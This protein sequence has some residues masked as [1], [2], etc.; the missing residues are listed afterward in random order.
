MGMSP[1]I[2]LSLPA[3]GPVPELAAAAAN[4]GSGVGDVAGLSV[5][6]GDTQSFELDVALGEF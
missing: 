4:N 3:I 2:T 5:G 1:E 6:D